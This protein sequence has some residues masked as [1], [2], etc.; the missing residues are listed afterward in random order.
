MSK[1]VGV[2]SRGACCPEPTSTVQAP[3]HAQRYY[4]LRQASRAFETGSTSYKC[5]TRSLP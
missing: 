3:S 1:R 5:Q 4:A 2:C